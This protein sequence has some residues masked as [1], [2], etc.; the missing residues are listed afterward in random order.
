MDVDRTLKDLIDRE[1]IDG[2]QQITIEDN[3]PK[4]TPPPL[5]L[6][7]GER[8]N[9]IVAHQSGHIGFCGLPLG[10]NPWELHDQQPPARVD[11]GTRLGQE[12]GQDT[13]IPT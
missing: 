2:N 11:F 6:G 1:D 13:S 9:V 3:G 5:L 7:H 8:L 12:G 10:R 4:V